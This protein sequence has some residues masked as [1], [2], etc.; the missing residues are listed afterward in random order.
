M[1]D[2]TV[3]AA[4]AV[5]R[6]HIE[7]RKVFRRVRHAPETHGFGDNV[8]DF[9]WLWSKHRRARDNDLLPHADEQMRVYTQEGIDHVEMFNNNALPFLHGMQNCICKLMHLRKRSL[10][11]DVQMIGMRGKKP[12]SLS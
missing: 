5:F 10:E 11:A 12:P 1:L 7:L 9:L 4:P 8:I 3:V 6:R 2:I